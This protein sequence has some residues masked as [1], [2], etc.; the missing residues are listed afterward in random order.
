MLSFPFFGVVAC[1]DCSQQRHALPKFGY[2]SNV[3]CCDT[4]HKL[5]EMQ[6]SNSTALANLHLKQLKQYISYYELPDRFVIEKDDLVRL[7]FNTRPLTNDNELAYRRHR[8]I[9]YQKIQ[10]TTNTRTTPAYQTN[11]PPNPLATAYN[12]VS[13][14]ISTAATAFEPSSPTQPSRPAPG[15]FYTPQPSTRPHPRPTANPAPAVPRSTSRPSP[16]TPRQPT[17]PSPTPP[18]SSSAPSHKPNDITLKE[19]VQKNISVSALPV[20][21]LKALLVANRVELSHALEKQELVKRVQQLVEDE[22]KR[23]SMAMDDDS[24]DLCRICCEAQQN[25][26]FLDCCHMVAC[27]DCGMKLVQTKNE[28]PICR[29]PILKVVRVFRS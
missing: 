24:D 5:I 17:R 10:Q 25:A 19:I 3:R 22:Q 28:C 16:P 4:C 29:A 12:R 9:D 18:P 2:D 11:Q 7:I 15:P 1:S 13:D 23:A 27:T 14:F 26:L 21:T 6:Q 8:D 20:K